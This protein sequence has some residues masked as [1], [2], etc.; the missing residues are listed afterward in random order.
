M[1]SV[2]IRPFFD[3]INPRKSWD[4]RKKISTRLLSYQE[5]VLWSLRHHYAD[6]TA[7]I[8]LPYWDQLW[9]FQEI[10]SARKVFIVIGKGI[11]CWIEF[12]FVLQR[13]CSDAGQEDEANA[14]AS[15]VRGTPT[16]PPIAAAVA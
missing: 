13:V 7:C 16:T 2:K 10:F 5:V 8:G 15:D 1:V 3:D 11:E 4:R 9:I 14:R 6:F 12:M